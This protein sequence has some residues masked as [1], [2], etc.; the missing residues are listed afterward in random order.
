MHIRCRFIQTALEASWGVGAVSVFPDHS[1]FF[2][3]TLPLFSSTFTA[4]LVAITNIIGLDRRDKYTVF[5]DSKSA[6]QVHLT[7]NCLVSL[8]QNFLCLLHSWKKDFIFFWVQ[9]CG[10][11]GKRTNVQN[12]LPRCLF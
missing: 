9:F 7:K 2:F 6:L 4:E 11:P 8:L 1:F 12:S 5:S 3:H 10:H